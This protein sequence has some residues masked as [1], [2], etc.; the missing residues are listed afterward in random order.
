MTSPFGYGY[1]CVYM[2]LASEQTNLEECSFYQENEI[3][4]YEK[5][6][7]EY[8]VTDWLYRSWFEFLALVKIILK[9]HL[10]LKKLFFP[11]KVSL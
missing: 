4:E 5:G 2:W 7:P 10:F 6:N 3:A 8:L 1:V 11:L 9:A